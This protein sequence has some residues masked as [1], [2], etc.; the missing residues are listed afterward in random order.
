MQMSA[1]RAIEA[2]KHAL[3]SKF[4]TRCLL[5]IKCKKCIVMYSSEVFQWFVLIDHQTYLLCIQ[6]SQAQKPTKYF[7]K[8]RK[9]FSVSL[10]VYTVYLCFT[11]HRDTSSLDSFTLNFFFLF[12]YAFMIILKFFQLMKR[13]KF[14]IIQLDAKYLRPVIQ[15]SVN[16]LCHGFWYNF[17]YNFCSI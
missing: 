4:P 5:E 3:T 15:G 7:N 10:P 1:L 13:R 8:H 16:G 11:I 9:L 14:L 12:M 2:I 17:S 6:C